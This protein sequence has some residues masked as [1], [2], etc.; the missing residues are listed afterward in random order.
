MVIVGGD[1]NKRNYKFVVLTNLR[2]VSKEFLKNE[3]SHF[4][5]W[6]E[7]EKVPAGQNFGNPRNSSCVQCL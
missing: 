7:I 4:L 1:V 3:Y 6:N 5:N 2:N